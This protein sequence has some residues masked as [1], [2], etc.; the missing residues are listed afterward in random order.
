MRETA[1]EGNAARHLRLGMIPTF[2]PP[3]PDQSRTCSGDPRLC[4]AVV[5]KTW[6]AATGAA[7]TREGVTPLG[8]TAQATLC[9]H[10][11]L[12]KVP[13]L[14]YIVGYPRPTRGAL[15]R[16]RKTGAE[17]GPAAGLASR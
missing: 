14:G 13:R 1:G 5:P 4:N 7:M 10:F 6:V 8:M 12:D 2:V 3:T 17:S 9:S 11:V 16:R 15:A